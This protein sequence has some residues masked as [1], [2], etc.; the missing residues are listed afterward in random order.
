MLGDRNDQPPSG[1]GDALDPALLP[2]L[3]DRLYRAAWA[4]CGSSHD[5]ED[6]VQETF[7]RVLARPRALRNGNPAP[8]LM[9]ALRNTYLTGLRTASRRPRTSELPDDESAAMQST[10]ARPEVAFEHQQTFAAIAE[11]GQDFREAL[12]AVDIVGLSYRE[13]AEVVGTR[14]ATITTRLFRARQAVAKALSEED[15][16]LAGKKTA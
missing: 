4:I 5:A 13:A 11:L 8:Y 7:A 15:G 1:E 6:L 2:A 14:E 9:Q 3:V 12:V 10:L 16:A